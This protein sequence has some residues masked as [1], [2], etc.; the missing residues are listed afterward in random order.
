M[1]RV[2]VVADPALASYFP[3]LYPARVEATLASG[4]KVETLVTDA[5]GD[6]AKGLGESEVR[7]KFHR[8]ADPVIGVEAAQ[9]LAALALAAT[10]D[11]AAL[12]T[13]SAA[14]E[15]SAALN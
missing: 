14:V 11:D 12:A 1:P 5:T 9:R 7:A 8:L 4:R 13:L 2:E 10:T 3:K 15:N 6:P